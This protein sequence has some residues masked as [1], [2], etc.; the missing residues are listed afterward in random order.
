MPIDHKNEIEQN[1]ID[2]N[3]IDN[4]VIDEKVIDGNS[5]EMRSESD[6]MEIEPC[7]LMSLADL[8]LSNT[9][10]LDEPMIKNHDNIEPFEPEPFE[11]EPKPI[12]NDIATQNQ[13]DS[14]LDTLQN[15]SETVTHVE[16][17]IRDPRSE[18]IKII[19]SKEQL[20]KLGATTKKSEKADLD[21]VC[22]DEFLPMNDDATDDDFALNKSMQDSVSNDS[23]ESLKVIRDDHDYL[24][25]SQKSTWPIIQNGT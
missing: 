3:V 24:K 11:P 20:E 12:G 17:P 13:K 5:C 7:P 9:P 25:W 6:D 2:E 4:N 8:D 1:V 15:V 22:Q 21:I 18:T 23:N 10:D 14:E 16:K 19:V